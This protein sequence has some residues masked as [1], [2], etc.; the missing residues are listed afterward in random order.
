MTW[1]F[2]RKIGLGILIGGLPRHF[3]AMSHLAPAARCH[4]ISIGLL[5]RRS[6]RTHDGCD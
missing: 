5:L 2:G 6:I 3:R 1:S 4:A